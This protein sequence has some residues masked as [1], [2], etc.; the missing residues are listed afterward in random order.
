MKREGVSTAIPSCE[1]PLLPLPASHQ[2]GLLA[3]FMQG[4][5]S[6]STHGKSG[7]TTR[8]VQVSPAMQAQRDAQ[9]EAV[10]AHL[11]SADTSGDGYLDVGEVAVRA[12]APCVNSPPSHYPGRHP[13]HAPMLA[14]LSLSLSPCYACHQVWWGPL[15]G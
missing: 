5:S 6:S 9:V 1:K 8:T 4:A 12:P 15:L 10:V 7:P 13:T 2:N 14:A 11:A 3:C